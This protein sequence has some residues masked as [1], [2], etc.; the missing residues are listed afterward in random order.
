MSQFNNPSSPNNVISG[1]YYCN[2]EKLDT[3]NREIAN[4]N[5]PNKPLQMVFDPSQ[6]QSSY[7]IFPV[8]DCKPVSHVPI[9][10][11]G[12]YNQHSQF[13][14]GTSAPFQGFAS[15]IDQD[16]RLKDMFMPLQKYTGQTEYIPSSG[17]DL[18]KE[19]PMTNS[20][21]V[22]MTHQDLFTQPILAPFNPNP[23][24]LGGRV[25]Y[26]HTRQQVKDLRIKK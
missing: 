4:R 18:Y 16:S 9:Q 10:N 22:H 24:H 14:P 1:V 11:R 5:I 2:N 15:H 26:N 3:M 19:Q 8:I 12:P 23:C 21:P 7:V 6:V 17:S 13:N 20:K 25:L